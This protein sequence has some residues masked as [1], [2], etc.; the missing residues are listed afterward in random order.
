MTA[1]LIKWKG[2]IEYL[3]LDALLHDNDESITSDITGTIKDAIIDT[4]RAG[5]LLF[6]MTNDRMEGLIDLYYD[7]QESLSPAVVAEAEKIRHFADKLDAVLF[8]IMNQRA[9]NSFVAP[10]LAGGIRSLEGAWRA[11]PAPKDELDRLWQTV[12]LP[13][14]AAHHGRGARGA[15]PSIK[16]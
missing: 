15:H 11:L 9:G 14:L 16:I 3:L 6:D 10:A 12:M 1:K 4:E 8:L 2:S 13:T 5:E 7:E